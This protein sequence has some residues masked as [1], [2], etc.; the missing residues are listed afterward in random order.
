MK[1]GRNRYYFVNGGAETYL[2]V[3]RVRRGI[4]AS[5]RFCRHPRPHAPAPAAAFG[6]YFPKPCGIPAECSPL[7]GYFPLYLGCRFPAFAFLVSF[8]LLLAQPALSPTSSSGERRPP[9]LM[10]NPHKA[11]RAGTGPAYQCPLDRLI[12][13]RVGSL[14]PGAAPFSRTRAWIFDRRPP[15]PCGVSPDASPRR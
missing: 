1:D 4:A 3:G 10:N 8:W 14:T 5:G 11:G 13:E 12:S 9:A 2:R 6:L 15:F 7:A